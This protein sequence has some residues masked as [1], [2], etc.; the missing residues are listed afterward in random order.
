V[1]KYP[2][3]A[4][5]IRQDADNISTL[6]KFFLPYLAWFSADCAYWSNVFVMYL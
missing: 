5:K 6:L 4:A 1:E 3:S 2:G